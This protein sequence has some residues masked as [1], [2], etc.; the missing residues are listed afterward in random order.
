MTLKEK[1]T[2]GLIWSFIDNGAAL[3]INFIT[4]IILARL[5]SPKEFGLIGMITIFIAI[6][7]TFI[8]SGF[9]QALIRK[10]NCTQI[11]YSTIFY[12]NIIV[13][14]SFYFILFGLASPIS[15]FY[16][17]PVLRDL[18]R[19]LG[20]GLIISS[21]T[22][23]QSAILT[24]RIDFKLQAKISVTS[25]LVSGIISI[26][27]AYTGWGVWSLVAQTLLNNAM[28]SLLL[29]VWNKWIPIWGFS[30]Q[31]FHEL[32]SFGSKL[33]VSGLIDT[34]FNNIY[35]LVIGKY[36]SATELGYYTRANGFQSLPSSNLSSVIGRVSYPVL[37]SI[38]NDNVQLKSAYR[39]LIR[40]TMLITFVLMLGLAAVAKPMIVTLIGAKWLPSVIL[41]Q[42]LCFVGMLYPLHAMNLN[43]LNVKGRSD[44]FLRLEV[45]KKAIA[46]PTIIIGVFFGIKIMIVGL[47]VSSVFSYY[48]NSYYSGKMIDYS[49]FHQI[50]DIFPSF[51]IAAM[52]ASVVY[53]ESLW[54]SLPTLMI[55]VIQIITG[56]V[57]WIGI[58]EAIRFDDYLY[59]KA[60]ISDMIRKKILK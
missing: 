3:G 9:S 42:M 40:S 11:D 6:S 26:Y 34:L 57:L 30:K 23:I 59:I 5:L 56:S 41:L 25:S 37:S 31:S 53:A 39:K 52:M 28:N 2:S 55:L 12:F 15:Q 16:H 54:L 49:M 47:F 1:T 13:G 32:F 35:Y 44:L 60:L 33:L 4:G 10:Q 21:L 24:K 46:I 14:I 17:E 20:L 51:L 45:I 29:W 43:M 19:V 48:L 8:N 50:K 36:F 22:V 27:L 58:C 38:Q 7:N 18:I